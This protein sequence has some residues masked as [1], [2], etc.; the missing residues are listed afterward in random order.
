MGHIRNTGCSRH[1]SVR[2]SALM[3]DIPSSPSH[4]LQPLVMRFRSAS[5]SPESK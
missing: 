3:L 1:S 2:V 5:L 4:E